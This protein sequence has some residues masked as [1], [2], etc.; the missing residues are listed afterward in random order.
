MDNT[1]LDELVEYPV[2]ALYRIG[3]DPGVAKLLLDKEEVD[4]D[5][6]D[7]DKVFDEFLF[8]YGYVDGTTT[9]AC[10]Y[11]CVEAEMSNSM[12]P[13][14]KN[15][16]LYVTVVCHKKFMKLDPGKFKGMLGNRRDNL[17][18][19]ADGI[20]NGS[21]LFG[22]GKLKL[23][24]ARTAPAPAGFAARELVYTIPDFVKK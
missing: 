21:D 13:S 24:S 10:A 8:D 9:E 17:A 12:T 22:V 3:S 7:G 20:L 6:N 16:K 18:R 15:M 23:L 2:Q 11:I 19:L 4:L 5:G 1:F 14:F